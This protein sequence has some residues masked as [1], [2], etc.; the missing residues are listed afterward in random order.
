VYEKPW[1]NP[2]TDPIELR[3]IY[4]VDLA[5]GRYRA[6]AEY[7]PINLWALVVHRGPR[8]RLRVVL[9][10]P[11][12]AALGSALG[13]EGLLADAAILAQLRRLIWRCSGGAAVDRQAPPAEAS[14]FL[15]FVA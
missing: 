12:M 6:P 2:Q 3:T 11:T 8:G 5:T 10:R 1:L 15:G 14:Q 7:D 4:I 9:A 13:M